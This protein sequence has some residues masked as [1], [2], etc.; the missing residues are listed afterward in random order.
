MEKELYTHELLCDVCGVKT[1]EYTVAVSP[2]QEKPTNESLG[3][4]S[5]RCDTHKQ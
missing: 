1:G 2:I 3:F 4:S 5:I